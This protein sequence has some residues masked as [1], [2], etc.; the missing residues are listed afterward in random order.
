MFDYKT[1]RGQSQISSIL[2]NV[3]FIGV[4]INAVWAIDR[5]SSNIEEL[6]VESLRKTDLISPLLRVSNDLKMD[7][8][9][10][11]QWITD[12]WLRGPKMV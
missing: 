11:Q 8:V 7:V 12:I 9:Q 10:V 6:S 2:S 3:V 5:L 1:L 4:L